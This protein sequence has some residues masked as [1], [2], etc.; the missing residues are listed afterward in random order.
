M[1]KIEK[2]SEWFL[3]THHLLN[4]NNFKSYEISNFS[5]R[6]YECKHNLN[7]WKIKPYIGYG[8]SAHSFD[9]NKRWYNVK[10]IDHY[11]KRLNSYKSPVSF[12][13]ILSIENKVNETIGFGLRTSSGIA[14]NKIPKN[15]LKIFNRN[16]KFA[17]KKWKNCI[18]TD[19]DNVKLNPNGLLYGDAIAIDLMI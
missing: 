18:I 8:P 2:T 12:S 10:S 4:H 19:N 9:G 6:G 16:L 7:Y 14:I 11:M 13:E 17:L 5:K 3:K 15:F 1:P